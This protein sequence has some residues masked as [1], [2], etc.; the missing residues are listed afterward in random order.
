[1]FF[2]FFCLIGNDHQKYKKY[3]EIQILY[4]NMI[5]LYIKII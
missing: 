1:M 3:I 5:V 2:F 4:E